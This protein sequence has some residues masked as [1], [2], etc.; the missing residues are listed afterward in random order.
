MDTEGEGERDRIQKTG[1]DANCA[2]DRELGNEW[3]IKAARSFALREKVGRR[4]SRPYHTKVGWRL[5]VG[6]KCLA[7]IQVVR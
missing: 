2:N 6:V 4:G 5:F 3:N 1:T 7:G